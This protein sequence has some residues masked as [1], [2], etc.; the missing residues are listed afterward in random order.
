MVRRIAGAV[1]FLAVIFDLQGAGGADP[2]GSGGRRSSDSLRCGRAP[3]LTGS[4]SHASEPSAGEAMRLNPLDTVYFR[5][6]P[7]FD[8]D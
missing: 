6:E 7:V 4:F 2:A 1:F 5:S 8:R 3:A